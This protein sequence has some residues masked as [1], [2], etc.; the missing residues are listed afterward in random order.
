MKIG[1]LVQYKGNY[2]HSFGGLGIVMAL[3]KRRC[4]VKMFPS[5]KENT[6]LIKDM[7]ILN[8]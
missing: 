6:F 4:K 2:H 1:D 8:D 5:L 3:S 7:E